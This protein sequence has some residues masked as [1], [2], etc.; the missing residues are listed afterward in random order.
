MSDQVTP[1]DQE[2]SAPANEA[3]PPRFELNVVQIVNLACNLLAQSVVRAKPDAAKELFKKLKKTERLPV[4]SLTLNR[5]P[6]TVD[7][8]FVEGKK[9]SLEVGVSI[10]LNYSEFRG[11]FG[12]P[13]FHAAVRELLSRFAQVLK[14]KKDFNILTSQETGS[15]LLHHPAV[16]QKDEQYNVLVMAIEPQPDNAINLALMF[17]DPDQYEQLRK[18]S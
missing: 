6:R 4:G 16:I 5:G 9:E 1:A 11:Q 10:S 18:D 3:Q 7:G 2:A 13:L 15:V 17:V 12:F 8:N 14:D